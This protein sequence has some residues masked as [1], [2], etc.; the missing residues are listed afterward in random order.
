M[1]GTGWRTGEQIDITG[2]LPRGVGAA[3][4]AYVTADASGEFTTTFRLETTPDGGELETGAYT[5]IARSASGQVQIPFLV[6]TRRPIQ[7]GGPGG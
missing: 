4:Y 6:E 2:T 1:T 5:L 7:G 3:P